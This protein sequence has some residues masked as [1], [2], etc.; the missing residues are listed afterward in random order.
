MS[1][2]ITINPTYPCS[3]TID[4]ANGRELSIRY[5]PRHAAAPALLA[6]LKFSMNYQMR[7]G[8]PCCC[9]AGVNEYEP[10]GK[11]AL[12]HTTDCDMR[13]AAIAKADGILK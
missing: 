3:C 12:V 2:K 7:D 6:A 13:R 8:S 1:D 11:M 4:I 9:P 10:T 5:C